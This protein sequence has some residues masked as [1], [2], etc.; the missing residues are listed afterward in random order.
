MHRHNDPE[1]P[2][3]PID[4]NAPEDGPIDEVDAADE[5]VVDVDGAVDH[6]RAH[7]VPPAANDDYGDDIVDFEGAESFPASDPPAG[8]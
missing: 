2:P 3:R 1:E 6:E 4:P 8:W 5:A 7:G